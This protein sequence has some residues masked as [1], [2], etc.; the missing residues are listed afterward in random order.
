MLGNGLVHTSSPG[1]SLT[2]RPRSSNT[3]TAIPS[4]AADAG[5]VHVGFDLRVDVIKTV[6][7]ERTTRGEDP[8]QLRQ[9]VLLSRHEAGFLEHCEILRACPEDRDP[10]F[11]RHLP[12]NVGRR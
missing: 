2:G 1:I 11:Y 9:I 6:V 3:S 4:P 8:F 7:R 12:Q 10:L 5:E